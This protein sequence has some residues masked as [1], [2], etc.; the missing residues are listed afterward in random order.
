MIFHT[1]RFLLEKTRCPTIDRSCAPP[2]PLLHDDSRS[3]KS[4]FFWRVLFSLIV[5][6]SLA[7]TPKL[8][9]AQ[10]GGRGARGG[11]HGG[12]SH[13]GSRGLRRS[14]GGHY[15]SSFRGGRSA[16]SRGMS[17]RPLR[18]SSGFA[19][20]PYRGSVS[21]W[22][23]RASDS[24]SVNVRAGNRLGFGSP[25]ARNFG[26]ARAGRS[27]SPDFTN[28]TSGWHSFGNPDG[29]RVSTAPTDGGAM[30]AWHSFAPD[31]GGPTAVSHLANAPSRWHSFSTAEE[32]SVAP[33]GP[34]MGLGLNRP[35][36]LGLGSRSWSGQ[37]RSLGVN[38]QNSTPDFSSIPRSNFGNS[39]Y[40]NSALGHSSFS[41]SRI[42]SNVS[43]FGGSR[44]G[45][46]YQFGSSATLFGQPTSLGGGGFSFPSDLFSWLLGF[47]S[48]GLRGLSLLDSGF[49]LLRWDGFPW[50]GLGWLFSSEFGLN[51]GPGSAYRTP[52]PY[53]QWRNW[54]DLLFSTPYS[55]ANSP[56]N[57]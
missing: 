43:L 27:V 39:R 30:R 8:T 44:F 31:S 55:T 45:S 10:H 49:G 14:G 12:G 4:L 35:P 34:S 23:R 11:S 26:E 37:G 22:D 53:D 9:L 46:R 54:G 56:S 25:L 1:T 13:G 7:C 16:V 40:R 47:G 41:N 51:A 28:R 33:R 2:F 15:G 17:A 5:S 50:F 38:A 24:R 32:G 3:S 6:F 18:G 20:R 36:T 19:S 57:Y 29:H 42:G 48:F 21:P 52:Y